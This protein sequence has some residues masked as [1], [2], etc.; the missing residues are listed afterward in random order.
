MRLNHVALVCS[1]E[2]NA[3]EFYVGILGLERMRTSVLPEELSREI[4]NIG[5]EYQVLVYG[6][7][8]F[9]AEVFIAANLPRGESRFE[10]VCLE[11]EDVETF[12]TECESRQVRVNRVFKGDRLLTF[13]EDFDGNLLEIK[14]IA[15]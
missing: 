12:V 11:V 9:T 15:K 3:N 8:R 7:D 14:E 10:H 13:V 5:G 2:E 1:S 6:N 4:F